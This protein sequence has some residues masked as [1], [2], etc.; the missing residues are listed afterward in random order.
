MDKEGWM[1]VD[2]QLLFRTKHFKS[3]LSNELLQMCSNVNMN[4]SNQCTLRN[5]QSRTVHCINNQ[6]DL[7]IVH[8]YRGEEYETYVGQQKF[9]KDDRPKQWIH[10]SQMLTLYISWMDN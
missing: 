6:F 9:N 5:S 2:G 1:I 3:I 8:I 7:H 10:H 4:L